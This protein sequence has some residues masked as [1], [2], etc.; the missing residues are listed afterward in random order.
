MA[1]ITANIDAS[2]FYGIKCIRSADNGSIIK[3]KI[4]AKLKKKMKILK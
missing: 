2:I 1:T 3:A 4:V